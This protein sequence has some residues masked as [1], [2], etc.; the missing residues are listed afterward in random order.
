[1]KEAKDRVVRISIIVAGVNLRK[2]RLI[3][4]SEPPTDLHYLNHQ[5][6]EALSLF[7]L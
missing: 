1:V 5:T 2:A 3:K 4:K 6:K 7:E